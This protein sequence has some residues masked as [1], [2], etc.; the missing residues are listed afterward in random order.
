MTSSATGRVE[1]PGEQ[2]QQM[3]G[4]GLSGPSLSSAHLVVTDNRTIEIDSEDMA[5]SLSSS[6][7][8]NSVEDDLLSIILL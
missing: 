2:V 7:D 1:I 4:T 6:E 8:E 5:V 3:Q